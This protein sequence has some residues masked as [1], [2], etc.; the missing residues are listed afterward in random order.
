MS[1][2]FHAPFTP[3]VQSGAPYDLV[4]GLINLGLGASTTNKAGDTPLHIAAKSGHVE[5]S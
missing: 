4:L 5:V 1:T 3:T 2:P